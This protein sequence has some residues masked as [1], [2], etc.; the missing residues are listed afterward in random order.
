MQEENNIKDVKEKYWGKRRIVAVGIPWDLH[1]ECKRLK[2][3]VSAECS[4]HL[5]RVVERRQPKGAK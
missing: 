1:D 2:L 4:K 3:N 5:R